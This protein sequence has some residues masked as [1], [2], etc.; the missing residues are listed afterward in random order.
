MSDTTKTHFP[1]QQQATPAADPLK[2]ARRGRMPG[3]VATS[4]VDLG[5]A[6]RPRPQKAKVKRVGIVAPAPRTPMVAM[7]APEN[8]DGFVFPA[9]GG[10]TDTNVAFHGGATA[11]SVSVQLIFWGP[12]WNA[13]DAGLR[14]QLTSAAMN[15]IDGPVLLSRRTVRPRRPIV[16]RHDD[17]DFADSAGVVR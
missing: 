9:N 8:A 4:V 13:G 16:P 14:N 2:L 3:R 12:S 1:T 17:G 7:T 5:T 11:G 15:L 6:L 10:V